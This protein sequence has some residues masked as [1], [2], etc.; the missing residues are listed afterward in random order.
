VHT[1]KDRLM[2]FRWR[3]WRLTRSGTGWLSIR[4]KSRTI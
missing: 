1:S 4:I 3:G 2:T